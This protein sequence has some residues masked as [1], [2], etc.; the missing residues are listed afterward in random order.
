MFCQVRNNIYF[1]FFIS[2]KQKV[3]G[4]V[5]A[6]EK[7]RLYLGKG[8]ELMHVAISWFIECISIVNITLTEK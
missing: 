4:V 3:G 2:D 5:P 8:G 1:H 6:I 7:P